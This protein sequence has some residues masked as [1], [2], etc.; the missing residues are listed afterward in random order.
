MSNFR[1]YWNQVWL[2]VR[3][4]DVFFNA[5]AVTFNLFICAIPFS[6]IL[7][8]IIGYILSF[9]TAYT[10]LTRY[11]TELLPD[12]A[13]ENSNQI[14]IESERIVQGLILPLV[15][16]RNVLGITGIIIMLFFT[17][18]LFHSLKM[19]L[20]DVFDIQAQNHPLMNI[21]YNF[22]GIGLLGSVFLFF[23]LLI[24]VVSLFDLRTIS[25][26]YTQVVIQLPWIYE[27]LDVLLPLIFTFLLAFVVFRFMSDRQINIKYSLLGASIFTF[28]F[29]TAKLLLSFY[30]NYALS[31][32]ESVYQSYTVIIVLAFW[33]FY[34]SILFVFSAILVKAKILTQN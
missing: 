30:L 28:L 34:L 33:V 5:S 13:Y 27:L 8:S 18:G 31:S 12:L 3:K 32:Y 11:G 7:I 22:L 20:F 10:E 16:G 9:E 15:E 4:V 25:I 19:V 14:F 17:Q 2:L 29:E 26:P 24:S 23:S 1:A 21:V 6:L